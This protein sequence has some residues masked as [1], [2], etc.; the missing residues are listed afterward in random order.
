MTAW[1]DGAV[2]AARQREIPWDAARAA[3]VARGV[4]V[5]RERARIRSTAVARLAVG[6]LASAALC[7][8]LVQLSQAIRMGSP[9]ERELAARH[10]SIT[11]LEAAA[12]PLFVERPVGDGGD[13]MS[14]EPLA[15]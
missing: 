12:E 10:S 13:A 1:L 7:A 5:G 4:D 2:Q 15:P 14:D 6:G 8:S 9:P 11:P 3:R